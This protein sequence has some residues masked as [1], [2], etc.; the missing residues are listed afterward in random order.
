MPAIIFLKS[1]AALVGHTIP[2]LLMVVDN[3]GPH[4]HFHICF[5]QASTCGTS[6]I[7][8]IIYIRGAIFSETV[9]VLKIKII[10][11]NYNHNYNHSLLAV[12]GDKMQVQRTNLYMNEI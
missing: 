11:H 7:F 5:Q 10:D 2:P 6:F 12:T 1:C 8:Q 3:M 4:H 9:H